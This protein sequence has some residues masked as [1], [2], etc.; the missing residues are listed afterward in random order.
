MLWPAVVRD[1]STLVRNTLF[2]V[3]LLF[4]V[5]QVL[6]ATGNSLSLSRDWIPVLVGADPTSDQTLAQVNAVIARVDLFCK[7]ASP[8]LLPVIYSIFPRSTWILLV[9]LTTVMVWVA[10]MYCLGH[11]S[12]EN[13]H[14]LSPRD[15]GFQADE[16]PQAGKNNKRPRIM[17]NIHSF[18]YHQPAQRLRQYFAMSVWPA[19]ICMA[20]LYLTVLVY[21]APLITYLLQR[22]FSLNTVTMA[23]ASG[24]LMGF[25]ATFTT[26]IASRYLTQSLPEGSFGKGIVPRRLSSWGIALQFLALVSVQEW[27]PIALLLT[28]KI[29]V[30]LILWSLSIS[31][32]QASTPTSTSSQISFLKIIGI[33]GFLSLSRFFH[34]TY[35]LMEQELEQ[36]E[37]P[38]TQRST[39]S[40]TGQAICSVFDLLHWIATVVWSRPDQFK[41]LAGASLCVVGGSAVWFWRWATKG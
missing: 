18:L 12:R 27:L 31:P 40:G 17:R 10:E 3:I 23:R 22:G 25:I 29:P 4:D 39:F 33:F 15:Q 5:V 9:T 19:S 21:S 7:V 37:V 41:G 2:G 28:K 13:P 32:D 34:W 1:D 6:S 26:P 20:F 11:I 8:S 35:E 16:I 24:S 38:A 14:L 36:S 30:V